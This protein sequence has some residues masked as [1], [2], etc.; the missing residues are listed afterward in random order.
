METTLSV[1]AIII[2]SISAVWAVYYNLTQNRKSSVNHVLELMSQYYS[3][4]MIIARRVAWHDMG[5][6]LKKNHELTWKDLWK[7]NTS[8]EQRLYNHVQRVMQFWYQ[9]YALDKRHLLKRN[10]AYYT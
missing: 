1:I 5:E 6:K 7:E 10:L 8:D 4:D 2:S 9:L 3:T